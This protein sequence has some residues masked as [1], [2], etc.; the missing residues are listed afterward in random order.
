MT[1]P[2]VK[3]VKMP[4]L[5][6]SVL[7]QPGVLDHVLNY[8]HPMQWLYVVL[9]SKL[10]LEHFRPKFGP[11]NTSVAT[12]WS[13]TE[14]DFVM[15]IRLPCQYFTKVSAAVESPSRL[16]FAHAAGLD[17][18]CPKLQRAVGKSGS[19]AVLTRAHQ[20][21]MPWTGAVS[22]GALRSRSLA[23]LQWLVVQHGCPLPADAAN[24]AASVG[25]FNV[26]HWFKQR[27]VPMNVAQLGITA[28]SSGHWHVLQYLRRAGMQW[29]KHLWVTAAEAGQL[30]IVQKLN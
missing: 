4:D 26:L 25:S 20:L 27:G 9:V 3:Q 23:K 22:Y 1:Q 21:G 19:A 15:R 24:V 10:W 6:E 12:V 2:S 14:R 29:S 30:A 18:L 17:L 16:E 7:S 8:V 13:R 28:A 11:E 5:H